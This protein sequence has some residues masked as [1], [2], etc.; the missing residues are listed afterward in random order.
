MG[1]AAVSALNVAQNNSA[2][3]SYVLFANNAHNTNQD[4]V[5]ML[6]GNFTIT[7][8]IYKSLV[9]YVSPGSPN[10]DYHL[11]SNSTAI[12]Q[13]FG[14]KTTFDI[15]NQSR[16]IGLAPDVGAVERSVIYAIN[17]KVFLPGIKR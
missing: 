4:S 6:P 5:P 11:S 3:L 9:G 14:S 13:A 17:F 15:D 7:N 12:D 10:Y 1:S 16:P 2:T 8:P